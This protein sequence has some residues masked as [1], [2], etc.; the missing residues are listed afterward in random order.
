MTPSRPYILR[1]IYEWLV[2]NQL[3]PYLMVDALQPFVKVPEKF[4]EDGKIVL[5]ISPSAVAKLML[6]NEAVQ[7][8]ASFSGVPQHI[9]VPIPA[10]KAIYAF[11]N[12]RGMIFS[13][14]EEED[15]DDGDFPP[16]DT[17]PPRKGPP[18]LKIVK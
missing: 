9:Y 4:V 12:G 7:F 15:D 3:T 14:E 13:E 1:A 5:N 16:D 8:N 17:S 11:E 18:N 2:D 10:V 6:S